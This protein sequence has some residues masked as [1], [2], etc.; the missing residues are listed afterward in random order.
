MKQDRIWLSPPHLS[1]RELDYIKDALD[2]N[3]VTTMGDNV[4][5]FER[6]VEQF[7]G[8]GR[9]V[10]ALSSG[11]AALHLALLL[12]GVGKDDIVLC[13]DMT[14][15]ATINP[16]AYVGARPVLVGSE[17]DTW[18]ISPDYLEE[19]IIDCID[20][21]RKPKVIIWVG[22]YGMPAKADEITAIAKKYD[23]RLLEDAAE[24]LGSAYKGQSCGA[25]GDLSILS[26][27][28]NKIVTGSAGGML[29]SN[30][31]E[32]IREARF[33]AGQA[34]DNTPWYQHSQIGYNYGM[35]N[36]VAGV[37]RGQMEALDERVE[38]RRW[39]NRFYR[40]HLEGIPGISF[41]TEPN[42][43]FFSN[44]WLTAI[45]IDKEQ[46]GGVDREQVRL[47]LE[48]ANIESRPVWMPMHKQPIFCDC[49]Y[50]GDTLSEDL[51][52]Q[53]LCLPS[54]TQLT[55]ANLM[56][57]VKTIKDLLLPTKIGDLYFDKKTPQKR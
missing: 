1:G 26:F 17:A 51:F 44:Y 30:N 32:D 29:L 41:H 21:G 19:A 46:T 52:N 31:G 55:E 47:A 20:K 14:F 54:G 50:Y 28:G 49:P 22:L 6:D 9:K 11:T 3:W 42:A 57:I 2:K 16:V 18:N 53:G 36:I 10:L 48:E 15:A 40:E 12:M 43:D 8:S 45:L 25:F 13:Q 38:R 34:R 33:L 27:N 5:G 56:R 24:S 37:G 39:N 7:V 4:T 35:S 23:I